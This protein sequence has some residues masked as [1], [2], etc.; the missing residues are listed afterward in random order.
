M[1]IPLASDER[2][3]FWP[4]GAALDD[5]RRSAFRLPSL[6]SDPV[7]RKVDFCIL[8]VGQAIYE[9]APVTPDRGLAI[10]K[11]L[12]AGGGRHFDCGSI[13][14]VFIH[15]PACRFTPGQGI[16]RNSDAAI[17]CGLSENISE[18]FIVAETAPENSGCV[19]GP[20]NCRAIISD[21]QRRT[22]AENTDVG[23]RLS[24]VPSGLEQTTSDRGVGRRMCLYETRFNY[25]E[26]I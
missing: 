20:A 6:K 24:F 3:P 10:K 25:H 14:R 21:H 16:I 1:D 17:F 15:I 4:C 7:R 8:D 26:N 12:P 22:W 5:G 9:G 11:T 18:P 13:E 19:T 2:P 23:A